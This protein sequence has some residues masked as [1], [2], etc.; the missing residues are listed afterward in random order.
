MPYEQWKAKYQKDDKK[1]VPGGGHK[2]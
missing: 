2:H 1:P